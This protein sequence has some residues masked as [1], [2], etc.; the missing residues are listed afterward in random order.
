MVEA[1]LLGH[2]EHA[3]DLLDAEPVED[4]VTVRPEPLMG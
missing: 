2:A 4:L 3:V 1:D